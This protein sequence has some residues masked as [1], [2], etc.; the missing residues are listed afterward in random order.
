MCRLCRHLRAAKAS[1]H[2]AAVYTSGLWLTCVLFTGRAG[3]IDAQGDGLHIAE[4]LISLRGSC[5]G[6]EGC[7]RRICKERGGRHFAG[8]LSLEAKLPDLW[9]PAQQEWHRILSRKLHIFLLLN[10]LSRKRRAFLQ[11]TYATFSEMHTYIVDGPP[12]FFATKL[13]GKN[14]GSTLNMEGL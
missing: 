5:C 14:V 6:L 7:S 12:A 3:Q 8:Q 2:V 13:C 4:T 9:K 1:Q 11:V 10:L